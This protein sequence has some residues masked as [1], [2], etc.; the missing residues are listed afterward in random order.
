MIHTTVSC[1]RDV[2]KFECA[3]HCV[4]RYRSHLEQPVKDFPDFK[5]GGNLS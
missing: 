1:G 5:E 3:N 2:N 4:K